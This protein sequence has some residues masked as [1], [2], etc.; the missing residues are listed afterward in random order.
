[1]GRRFVSRPVGAPAGRFGFRVDGN[2]LFQQDLT[3]PNG[4]VLSSAGNYDLNMFNLYLG[5]TPRVRFNTGIDYGRGP[6]TAHIDA[7]YIGGFDECAP[8]EEAPP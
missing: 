3:L 4:K 8:L 7:R 2:I 6:F 5:V 1:M